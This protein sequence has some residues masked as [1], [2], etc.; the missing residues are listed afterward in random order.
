M[1]LSK[2]LINY[3]EIVLQQLKIFMNN[4]MKVKSIFLKMKMIVIRI[5]DQEHTITLKFKQVLKCNLNL[6][7]YNFLDLLSKDSQIIK[8]QLK[9]FK[10]LDP[11]HMILLLELL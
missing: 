11:E 9:I 6:K 7:D 10:M 4:K 5:L 8:T 1:D 2:I 3:L